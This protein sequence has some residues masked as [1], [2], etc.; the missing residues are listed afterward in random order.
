ML[1]LRFLISLEKVSLLETSFYRVHCTHKI[2][3]ESVNSRSE[4]RV[5][6]G[7][8]KLSFI[9]R[10][11]RCKMKC[12]RLKDFTGTV[13]STCV[14]RS[15]SFGYRKRVHLAIENEYI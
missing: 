6:N 14:A 10:F 8:E 5:R 11:L 9:Y 4:N 12:I 13:S 1:L 2:N 3:E 7:L 15:R